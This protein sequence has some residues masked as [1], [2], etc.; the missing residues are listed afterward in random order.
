MNIITVY[1]YVILFISVS[2]WFG[3]ALGAIVARMK[4]NRKYKAF[5]K[6]IKFDRPPRSPGD[7]FRKPPS[8]SS[9][10]K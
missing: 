10:D 7:V 4:Y 1:A 8:F 5:A 2:Y 6:N 3:C 9:K